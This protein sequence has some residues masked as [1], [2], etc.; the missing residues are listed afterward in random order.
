MKAELGRLA[1]TALISGAMGLGVGVGIAKTDDDDDDAPTRAAATT[2]AAAVPEAP[3]PT[4]SEEPEG[5]TAREVAV[6][7]LEVSV[8]SATIQMAATESGRKRKRARTSV[9]V[10]VVNSGQEEVPALE[11][12][13]RSGLNTVRADPNATGVAGD[14]F[15]RLGAGEIAS[16]E[17]RFETAGEMTTRLATVR[18]ALLQIGGVQQ[19]VTLKAG[20]KLP[21]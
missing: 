20:P 3:V 12:V 19:R 14:L 16:G 17:L 1:A 4:T 2:T 18:S 5:D 15:D 7:G 11:P 6:R 13:L 9:I 10:R 21:S 8:V